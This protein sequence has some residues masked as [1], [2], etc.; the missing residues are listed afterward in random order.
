MAA[1]IGMK[2]TIW[3]IFN[4]F[5]V[6]LLLLSLSSPVSAEAGEWILT[7][8]L[9]TARYVQSTTLLSDGK[10]LITGGWSGSS[11][12]A[13]AEIYDPDTHIWT[14]T[15][16]M[17]SVRVG[18]SISLMSNGK[19]LVA[20]GA[21]SDFIMINSAE[22]YDPI[23]EKWTYTS[24]MNNARQNHTATQ[25]P[26]GEVLVVGGKNG[27]T[28]SSAIAS[29]ELYDP[30]TGIWTNTVSLNIARDGHGLRFYLMAEC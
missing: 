8:S 11:H 2:R 26:N 7:G 17:N 30:S 13:S 1:N 4:I 19:V 3:T 6:L 5:I 23:N 27:Q 18:H 22:L 12:L 9:N 21:I 15:G 28:H 25:L 16:S 14:A 24:S 29:C 20:G 10:V